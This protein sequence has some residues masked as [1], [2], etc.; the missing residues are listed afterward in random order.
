MSGLRRSG[1]LLAWSARLE[2]MARPSLTLALLD[3]PLAVCRLEPTSPVPDWA[4]GGLFTS[5][6]RTAQELSIICAAGRVPSDV[7]HQAGWRV[8]R[9]EGPFPFTLTG[10]LTSVAVPLADAGVPVLAQSTFDTDYV[11]VP[12]EHLGRAVEVLRSAGHQVRDSA[13]RDSAGGSGP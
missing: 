10:I 2:R 8:L 4:G 6:T 11:L 12:E 5:V 7:R 3:L 13:V 9:F 1:R